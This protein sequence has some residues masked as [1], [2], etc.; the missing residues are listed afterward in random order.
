LI[1]ELYRRLLVAGNPENPP[2][3]TSDD[4][5]VSPAEAARRLS[6]SRATVYR[7]FRSKLLTSKVVGKR[8]RRISV[9]ALR[10]LVGAR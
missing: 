5:W 3:Q 6:V 2:I 7:M 4:D 10:R 1:K 9:D 8:C